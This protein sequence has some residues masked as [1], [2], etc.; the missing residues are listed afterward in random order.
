MK[1]AINS[2]KVQDNLSKIAK[3]L[4]L[5]ATDICKSFMKNYVAE[6]VIVNDT[7]ASLTNQE[8][9]EMEVQVDPMVFLEDDQIDESVPTN[10][11]IFDTNNHL[12]ENGEDI[13]VPKENENSTISNC[14]EAMSNSGTELIEEKQSLAHHFVSED[15]VMSK[16]PLK[17]EQEVEK[18]Q[19]SQEPQENS[20]PGSTETPLENKKQD[21]I[22]CIQISKQD[23]E[24]SKEITAA[25]PL[26]LKKVKRG[27][28]IKKS[29]KKSDFK[30][31]PSE[32]IKCITYTCP[33]CK[34][35]LMKK[36]LF[37]THLETH[38]TDHK[39]AC[40]ICLRVFT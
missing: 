14:P 17:T 31:L 30:S 23:V 1:F 37:K 12:P 20:T 13:N 18:S 36:S 5:T 7:V 24:V 38:K 16:K 33:I 8:V 6:P 2:L 39:Y 19:V 21:L 28:N 35:V 32:N 25:V 29:L 34:K 9:T 11:T 27:G 10:E 26:I 4:P 40:E 3:E 22:G 15:I